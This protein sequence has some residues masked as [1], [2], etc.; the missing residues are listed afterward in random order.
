MDTDNIGNAPVVFFRYKRQEL[1]TRIVFYEIP[2]LIIDD[3]TGDPVC[4]LQV[5]CL[6][7][8]QIIAD[9]IVCR[10]CCKA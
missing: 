4:I 5:F 10:I 1:R 9:R 3:I 8:A 6:I 2:Y 7:S